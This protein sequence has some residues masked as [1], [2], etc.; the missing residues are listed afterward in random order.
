MFPKIKNKCFNNF[1]WASFYNIVFISVATMRV[2]FLLIKVGK[3]EVA[4]YFSNEERTNR[5]RCQEINFCRFMQHFKAILKEAQL[6]LICRTHM[7]WRN[8]KVFPLFALTLKSITQRIIYTQ[9]EAEA[10]LRIWCVSLKF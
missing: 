5:E 8:K 4:Y 9:A 6:H 1:L 3:R 7:S 10:I 2:F